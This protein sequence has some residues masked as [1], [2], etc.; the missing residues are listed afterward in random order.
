M[1]DFALS[2]IANIFIL[3]ILYDFCLLPSQFCYTIVYIRKVEN[4]VQIADRCAPWKIS[5]CAKN[6]VLQALQF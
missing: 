6:L 1:S 3:M 2:Y 4:R 5:N